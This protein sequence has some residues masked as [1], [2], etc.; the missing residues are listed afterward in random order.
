MDHLIHILHLEDDPADVELVQI[1]VEEAGLP[2]RITCVQTRPE[3]NQSLHQGGYDI[4]LA[5]YNLPMYDGMSA[6]R[7][8]QELCPD[9]PFIFVSGRMGEDAAIEALT[10]GAT[11]YV[12]KQ[13]LSRLVPAIK[14]ALH[15]AE[16]WRERQRAE[17]ELRKHHEHLEELVAARTAELAVAKE[18]AEA[19]N[20]A[21][22]V[23]LANMSHELRTP[24]NAILGYAQI[25]Q[26]R[27]LETDVINRL[28]II[29]QSGEHLLTLIND[30][31]DL[32]KVES[33]HM[34]LYPSSLHLSRFLLQI[35]EIIQA[36]AQQKGLKF[37][38]QVE[39]NLPTWIETDETRL[40]QVLLNLLGNAI[41]F[42]DVGQVTLRV[43]RRSAAHEMG[44]HEKKNWLRFEVEDTGPGISPNERERIFQPFEQ[45]GDVTRRAEGTGL[46]LTISRHLVRLMEGDL[47]LE[48]SPS[49]LSSLQFRSDGTGETVKQGSGSRF[50]F[51]VPLPVTTA[52]M[53][54]RLSIPLPS[55]VIIG[56]KG[57]RRKLLVADDIPSQRDVLVDLLRPLK[58]EVIT[59]TNG[60]EAIQLAQE[61]RPDLI[62]MDQSMP[63]LCGLKATQSIRQIPAL[64]GIPLIGISASV[65]EA[66]QALSRESGHDAFL[67][68]PISWPKL[69]TLLK[70]YLNLEWEYAETP[71]SDIPVSGPLIP[72][73]PEELAVLYELA[74]SGSIR[75]IRDKAVELETLGEEFIPFARKLLELAQ[76]YQEKAILALVEQYLE[77]GEEQ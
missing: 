62:L 70:E 29:Q 22:S 58:F 64:Q 33:G 52:A 55:Q 77:K 2:C 24:L 20:Q 12:L 59:A 44:H 30:I 47:G 67:P 5:D 75:R 18:K 74:R 41:K 39:E 32:S 17:E 35:T 7:L 34:Q 57:P 56:Y 16:N 13:K 38:Y 26:Q 21:K 71:A 63:A 14:R 66:D 36:R 45:V 65:T 28:N 37:Y 51:E 27:P 8:A 42:T 60:Q 1:K 50:W 3:F 61:T 68:K 4:I 76:G 23:F 40:R 53:E 15:E 19:A 9:I 46:G 11:D 69:A 6:L 54:S 73:P 43:G 48:S 25:L 72:P 31:L 49:S 10:Q